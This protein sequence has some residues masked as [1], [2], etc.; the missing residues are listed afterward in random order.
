MKRKIPNGI[1]IWYDSVIHS[2]ALSWQNKLCANNCRFFEISDGFFTNYN[3][4]DDDLKITDEII[5]ERYPDRRL[6]VFFGIDVFG[7]GQ[8]AQD[9]THLTV[10]RTKAHNFSLALFA[11][12]W[13]YEAIPNR[14]R[15]P[16]LNEVFLRRNDQFFSSFWKDLYTSGPLEMPFYS[17]FCLGSGQKRFQLG[18]LIDNRPWFDLNAQSISMSV[19]I[20]SQ[21]LKNDFS[22]AFEGGS[23]LKVFGQSNSLPLRLFCC[24]F[25]C[26]NDLIV[27][28]AIR[29]SADHVDLEILLNLV[30]GD[31]H[32]QV[33]CGSEAFVRNGVD[34]WPGHYRMQNLNEGQVVFAKYFLERTQEKFIP[35]GNTHIN[36]WEIR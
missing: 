15:T 6:D 23:C 5:K 27:A 26:E 19:P 13:T 16:N 28:Y 4:K 2:G 3:W 35:C 32:C 9:D 14:N 7:R 24:D 29:K 18:R 25:C 22:T 30:N 21:F 20:T 17:S 36:G 12:S 34:S 8:V 11:P 1:V 10:A 31:R 33:V